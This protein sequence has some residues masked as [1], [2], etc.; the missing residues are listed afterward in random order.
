M[1][2]TTEETIQELAAVGNA[3]AHEKLREHFG[4]VGPNFE[5]QIDA[6]LSGVA[7]M[8]CEAFGQVADAMK[9]AESDGD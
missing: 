4:W 6:I 2:E 3:A 9:A 1:A 5:G 8:I 7:A